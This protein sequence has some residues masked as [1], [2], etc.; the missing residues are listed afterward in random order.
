MVVAL[1]SNGT[2]WIG[3]GI[4]RFPV[5]SE[6]IFNNYVVL[7]KSGCYRFVNTSGQIVS[8]WPNVATVG[9]DTIEA[10]GRE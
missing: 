4:K 7:G 1:D 8:G 9:Q 10:M 5:P 2:A 3:D 6:A